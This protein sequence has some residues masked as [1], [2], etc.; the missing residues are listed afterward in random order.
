[1]ANSSATVGGHITLFLRLIVN[2]QKHDFSWKTLSF[3][4]LEDLHS[5]LLGI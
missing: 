5:G 4:P 3:V 1:M 2:G